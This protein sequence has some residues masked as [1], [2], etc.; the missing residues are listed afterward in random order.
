MPSTYVEKGKKRAHR[1]ENDPAATDEEIDPNASDELRAAKLRPK[2]PEYTQF[3]FFE[4]PKRLSRTKQGS[5]ADAILRGNKAQVKELID[6]GADVEKVSS[7]IADAFIT[8]VTN[9]DTDIVKFLLE[10]GVDANQKEEQFGSVLA[11]RCY[12]GDLII[13]GLL[14]DAG[15]QVD[16]QLELGPYGNAFGAA[17]LGG[18]A[19]SVAYLI[20]RGAD[21]NVE[22][23]LDADSFGTALEWA[24]WELNIDLMELLL[25]KGADVNRPTKDKYGSVLAY[26]C[27]ERPTGRRTEAV[28]VLLSNGANV[29]MQ[30]R[31][32]MFGSALAAASYCGNG[33]IA[34]LLLRRGA[35]VDLQLEYGTF[36]S[37]LAAAS[38][39]GKVSMAKFLLRRGAKVNLQLK[40]GIFGSALA[41]ASY[42]GDHGI[43]K[44]LIRMGA[45]INLQLYY[46][47]FGSA[48]AAAI[49]SQRLQPLRL[50]LRKGA[51][52]SLSLR[53]GLFGDAISRALDM[54]T[55]Y[56]TLLL[57]QGASIGPLAEAALKKAA[58]IPT[59]FPDN[60]LEELERRGIDINKYD[61][62]PAQKTYE[63]LP[64]ITMS[65][66]QDNATWL[67]DFGILIKHLDVV[68]FDALHHFIEVTYG[69]LGSNLV[70]GLARAASH[71]HCYGTFSY[72]SL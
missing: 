52:L 25:K 11:E 71:E 5:L 64:P 14:I 69:Q 54:E 13:S 65:V 56:L 4:A 57:A 55:V 32:G 1:I 58:R 40:Y 16:L 38:C 26:T 61:E 8:A 31:N 62:E 23:R 29:N 35:S 12:N 68:E 51:D 44:L 19:E 39:S 72:M 37:A 48:L 30:L 47:T 53:S 42:S 63:W 21:V 33:E 6:N 7:D 17:C 10:A 34:E 46:G 66:E 41:A 60:I 3:R 18:H 70:L 9:G 36:G 59:R 67:S 28:E 49:A 15:A 20:E 27:T 45:R 2:L 50:L 22:M 24:C 43:A